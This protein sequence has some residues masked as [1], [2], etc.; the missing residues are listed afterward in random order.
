MSKKRDAYVGRRELSRIRKD[1]VQNRC[2]I[3]DEE[4]E[5]SPDCDQHTCG[6]RE[7]LLELAMRFARR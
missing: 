2:E 6:R 4:Y 5:C 7:C 3:C 1:T